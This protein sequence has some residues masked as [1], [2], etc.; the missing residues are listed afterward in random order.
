MPACLCSVLHANVARALLVLGSDR[1]LQMIRQ[2]MID[3]LQNHSQEA[4]PP[5]C[6]PLEP[7]VPEEMFS[8]FDKHSQ[9][10]TA[11]IFEGANSYV[12]REV[13]LDLIQYENIVVKRMLNSDS[14][15][16]KQLGITS[17]PSSYLIYPNGSH[18]LIHILYCFI[19]QADMT[20]KNSAH[21]MSNSQS[22]EQL[23]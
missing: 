3:F 12:G 14:T 21:F 5:A 18:G 4:K 13:I 19:L 17:V 7:I 9:H 1:E 22:M 2:S 23:T 16:L 11:I 8:L 10:Y 20:L 6:P 15:V